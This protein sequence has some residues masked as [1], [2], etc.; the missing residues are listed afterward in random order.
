VSTKDWTISLRSSLVFLTR[1]FFSC[2]CVCVCA[3]HR[4]AP[5]PWNLPPDGAEE[6]DGYGTPPPVHLPKTDA[7]APTTQVTLPVACIFLAGRNGAV[8]RVST[9]RAVG[10]ELADKP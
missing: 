9:W 5:S 7:C 1:G 6:E 8:S 3:Q 2:A 4:T 10:A